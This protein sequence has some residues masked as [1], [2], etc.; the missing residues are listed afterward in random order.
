L[1][2]TKFNL[3]LVGN[4]RN[5]TMDEALKY[6][7]ENLKPSLVGLDAYNKFRQYKVRFEQGKLGEKATSTILE[8]FGFVKNTVWILDKERG[9]QETKKASDKHKNSKNITKR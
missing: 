2:Q 4:K 8:Y 1:L 9:K 5:F 3:Y 6:C 7:F